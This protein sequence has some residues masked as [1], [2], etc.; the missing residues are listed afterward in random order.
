MAERVRSTALLA[1]GPT[2]ALAA[3]PALAGDWDLSARA[4]ATETYSDNVGLDE[5]DEESDFVTQIE[6]SIQF[7]SQWSRH[8]LSLELG[9]DIAFHADESDE[10]YQD[11]FALGR[12]RVDVAGADG[13]DLVAAA[14]AGDQRVGRGDLRL[15][16]G[17]GRGALLDVEHGGDQLVRQGQQTVSGRRR[18][19]DG[20]ELGLRVAHAAD[21]QRH[22][23]PVLR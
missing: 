3:V 10:D 19:E 16:R 5:E 1:F 14:A 4:S 22:H 6:P 7:E 2:L 13:R 9:S 8:F 17:A 23:R 21:R 11:F 12:G 15:H 20:Q 18:V